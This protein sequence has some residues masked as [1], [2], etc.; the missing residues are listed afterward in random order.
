MSSETG[1][2]HSYFF[3]QL[4]EMH[5]LWVGHL[6]VNTDQIY[7]LSNV[8]NRGVCVWYESVFQQ[9]QDVESTWV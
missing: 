3:E 6:Q 9:T 8:L 4:G 2:M 1:T 7:I 5:N